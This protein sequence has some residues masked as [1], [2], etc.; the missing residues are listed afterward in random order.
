MYKLSLAK[1]LNTCLIPI[2]GYTSD[3]L[4][5]AENGLIEEVNMVVVAIFAGELF[6]IILYPKIVWKYIVR[7]Y[8]TRKGDQSDMTQKDANHLYEND[9]ASIGKSMSVM[10]VFYLT[11]LFYSPI[12]PM[13]TLI[14]I[15]GSTLLYWVL[16][17]VILRRNVIMRQI[18]SKLVI[19]TSRILKIGIL[20]YALTNLIFLS[21]LFKE[22]YPPSIIGL[23]VAI[24]FTILPIRSMLIDRYVLPVNRQINDKSYYSLIKCFQHYDLSNPVTAERALLRLQMSQKKKN[25]NKYTRIASRAPINEP[26]W[27][28]S[29]PDSQ[30][31]D[32][33]SREVE[34]VENPQNA[35]KQHN[36]Q[37]DCKIN[38]ESIDPD[39]QIKLWVFFQLYNIVV[40]IP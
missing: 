19:N 32:D 39:L 12:M 11:I 3:D 27:P 38:E 22:A 20:T 8:E 26:S 18:D 2:V 4:W 35:P 16:K 14:G 31:S 30:H 25:L 40:Q 17:V 10:F 29:E 5:F 13:I 36:N 24:M 6:R 21:S 7:I 9:E 23:I 28:E 1:F 15:I 34:K 33:L 37:E